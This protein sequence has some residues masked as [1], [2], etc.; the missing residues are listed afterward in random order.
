MIPPPTPA[1]ANPV[2]TQSGS[3]WKLGHRLVITASALLTEALIL[4]FW[5]DLGV[6]R[7]DMGLARVLYDWGSSGLRLASLFVVLTLIFGSSRA[8]LNWDRLSRSASKSPLSY[9]FL[10]FHALGF[11]AFA[12]ISAHLFAAPTNGEVV[13]WIITGVAA[14]ACGAFVAI[15]PSTWAAFLKSTGDGWVYALAS[16]AGAVALTNL[17]RLLWAPTTALTFRAVAFLLTPLLANLT[18]DVATSTI[19]TAQFAVEITPQCSGLEGMGLMLAFGSAWLWFFRQ[20]YRFPQ[21]L[22]LVPAGIA[23]IWILNSVRI[24][25]LVLIGNAGAPDVAA[26]GFHS[27]AGWISFIALA[28][29]LSLA[30][31]KIQWFRAREALS[32]PASR[33]SEQNTVAIYLGPFLA[34]LAAALL[35][36]AA[37][38]GFD[39]F[40]GTR[41]LLASLVLWYFRAE[42]RQIRWNWHLSSI[43]WGAAVFA[44]WVVWD[45]IGAASGQ[46]T[47]VA[48]RSMPDLARWAWLTIRVLAATITVPIAEELAFRGF[49][50]R[51]LTKRD[52]ESV[53]PQTLPAFAIVTSSIV[54]GILHGEMWLAGIL[55]GLVYAYCYRRHGSLGDAVVAHAVT[56]LL[57]S[58]YVLLTGKWQLW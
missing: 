51:S 50:A 34:I 16:A 15:P 2:P 14:F 40:Y 4:S 35:S 3:S 27:Q 54:F 18:S 29:L 33:I 32:Q 8:S 11:V 41:L 49:L 6:F 55:A 17:S 47:A 38:A 39:Y 37:S 12:L 24:A 52:F 9:K 46:R 10:A 22:I 56:N 36:S 25:V 26:G 28:L 19:G 7:R 58:M 30:S 43:A 57:L 44:V 21:A 48:L 20:Q 5:L 42:Y 13:V 31:R 1:L 45:P 23:A 53:D